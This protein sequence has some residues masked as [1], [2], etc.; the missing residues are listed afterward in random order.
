MA[1]F[2]IGF[3]GPYNEKEEEFEV[4]LC[5]MKH[6]FNANDM[7]VEKLI[8]VLLTPIGPIG[9]ALANNLLSF[10]SIDTCKFQDL[11]EALTTHY[12][13]K[14]MLIYERY[15]FQTRNQNSN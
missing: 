10:K 15:T 11:V 9:F 6:Y 5:R 1:H 14:K 8:S 7:K 3:I 13:P 2:Q 12:K 4:Y